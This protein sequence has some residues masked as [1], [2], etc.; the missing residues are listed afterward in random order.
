VAVVIVAGAAL[1]LAR[2]FRAVDVAATLH[3]VL[4]MGALAP[5]TL[6]PFVGGMAL[7]A[8]GMRGLLGVMGKRIALARLLPI[9]IATEAL[10][11]TAPAGFLVADSANAKLLDSHFGVPLSDGAMLAVARKWLVMRAHAVYLT[12]GAAC[13]A[14]TLAAA[15]QRYLG[16]GWLPWAVGG[17]AIVPLALSVA[18]G[19]GLRGGGMA[20]RLQRALLAVPWPVLRKHTMRWHEGAVAVDARLACIGRAVP[21]TW[22]AALAFLGAWLFESLDTAVVIKLVGGPPTF[23]FALASEVGISVLRSLGNVAPAGLG[24]QDAGYATLLPAMGMSPD[25]AAAFIL[26]KRAKELV[27]IGVGYG[28]LAV[29]RRPKSSHVPRAAQAAIARAPLREP[30]VGLLPRDA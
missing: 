17:C 20:L 2:A 29:L 12:L 25:V 9:R 4:R 3:A 23:A 7:D 22:I 15:S 16:G 24:V 13:G 5:L 19:Q 18:L 21:S 11:V 10:H 30:V 28:L 1:L 6:L 14:S 26:V 8:L 27:W